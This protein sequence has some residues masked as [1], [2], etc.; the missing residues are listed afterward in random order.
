SPRRS[1]TPWPSPSERRLPVKL[2]E[3][4]FAFAR[5][6]VL[7]LAQHRADPARASA[8]VA[9]ESVERRV[10]TVASLLV[11]EDLDVRPT[12]GPGGLR[13]DTLWLPAELGIGTHP[14]ENVA[15]YL[16]RAGL[17]AAALHEGFTAGRSGDALERSL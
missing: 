7:E 10:R 2:D 17:A 5:R 1:A 9:L 16:L 4:L 11:G 12:D 15:G 8:R 14:D 13:G 3:R 6:K